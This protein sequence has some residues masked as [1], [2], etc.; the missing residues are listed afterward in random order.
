MSTALPAELSSAFPTEMAFQK[1]WR[2]Y[3]ARLLDRLDSYLEDNRLHIVAAPGSGKTIFGLEVIRRLNRPT[4]VLAPTITIRNQWFQRLI[5][6]F[7]PPGS[8]KPAWASTDIRQPQSLT[9]ATYQALHALCAGESDEAEDSASE[10]DLPTAPDITNGNGNGNDNSSKRVEIP[11]TLSGFKTLVLDEAH[12]LRSEWWRTLNLVAEQLKPTLVALTA[13]PPYDV[14]PFEWQRYEDLCGPV[15]AEIAVPELVLQGDLCPHQDYVFLSTPAPA[16]QKT[17][18]DFRCSV[19]EFVETIKANAPFAAAVAAHPWMTDPNGHLEEIL[20]N[21][22][23]LSSMVIFLKSTGHEIS[24]PVLDALGAESKTVPD[25]SLDWLEVLLTQCLYADQE[26]FSSIDAMLKSLRHDL[27]AIGAV[28]RRR[29]VLR[30]PS[31]HTKLLTTSITKL[32]SMEQIVR[33]ESAALQNDL[34]CAI[35]TD[36]IRRSDLPSAPDEALEF[37]DIGAVP[38]FETLRRA[39]IPCVRLGVLC[40]SLVIVPASAQE[41][42]LRAAAEQNLP[43]NDLLLELMPH[44]HNYLSLQIPGEN[45][46]NAVRR[47]TSVFEQGGITV[48]IGTKALLGEGWDAPTINTLILATFVGSFVLSN[49]MR[50]RA[51]RVNSA[52]PAK[53]ANI[54]HLVCVEAGPFGSE[55]DYA[56][57]SRRCAAFVGVNSSSLAIEN[58]VERLG[59]AHPPFNEQQVAELNTETTRRAL[60][61]DRLRADWKDALASGQLKQMTQGLNADEETLPRKFVFRNTIAALL[62]EGIVFFST[63]L[64]TLAR[65]LGRVRADDALMIPTLILGLATIAGLPWVVVALWRLLRHGTPERSIEQIGYTVLDALLMEGSITVE[66]TELSVNAEHLQDG[67]VY[68]WLRGGSGRD[69][70]IFLRTLREVLRPIENPRYLLAKKGLWRLFG[71]DYFAVPDILGRKKNVAEFFAGKWAKAVGPVQLVYT[72]SPEGRRVLLRARMRSLAS[73][74]QSRAERLSC[75]K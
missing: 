40:G 55:V 71:E 12:H 44:D 31:D 42:V 51:I 16:E 18:T 21:P 29:V 7:L 53:T 34:R 37:E 50:G 70:S 43:A 49:Q 39:S 1:N 15:D 54:W 28:E 64:S 23:Y 11:E 72:R 33:L 17:L 45:R 35:L 32:H 67:S 38:I 9:I 36:Y 73:T 25:L 10:D 47:I 68:C 27:S 60:D 58:G 30:S 59:V 56:L 46:Q 3:Q 6:Q 41:L 26:S 57:L 20:D 75:W 52:V 65:A 13:T 8:S 24:K 74:F 69:Q 63:V 14:S 62:I 48:L 22:E 2:S 5:D 4:L 61:R 66:P 19:D